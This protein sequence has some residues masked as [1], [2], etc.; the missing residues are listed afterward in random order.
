MNLP[1]A[2]PCFSRPL[3]TTLVF[4]ASLYL[5]ALDIRQREMKS[6]WPSRSLH[7]DTG[8]IPLYPACTCASFLFNLTL[9]GGGC[10]DYTGPSSPHAFA[11]F[12]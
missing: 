8:E 1:P 12:M 11:L 9:H 2:R 5:S 3:A 4:S 10:T 7:H 6:V